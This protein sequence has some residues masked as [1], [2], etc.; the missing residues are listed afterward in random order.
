MAIITMKKTKVLIKCFVGPM[1]CSSPAELVGVQ[2]DSI[3][4]VQL[5]CGRF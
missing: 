3:T 4:A 2:W 5:G 1:Q